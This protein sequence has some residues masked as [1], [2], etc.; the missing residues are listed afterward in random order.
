MYLL[1]RWRHKVKHFWRHSCDIGGNNAI[2][3]GN[4]NDI[5]DIL[6]WAINADALLRPDKD[7]AR[8]VGKD[9]AVDMERAFNLV[10]CRVDYDKVVGAVGAVVG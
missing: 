4:S 1:E 8:L 10:G 3:E 5:L 2:Y 6:S 7:V 9:N